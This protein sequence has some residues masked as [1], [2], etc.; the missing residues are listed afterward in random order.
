MLVDFDLVNGRVD[1]FKM[2]VAD[3]GT[4][5]G[6]EKH[7]GGTP[8]YASKVAF[9]RD[10]NKDL[11]AFGRNYIWMSQERDLKKYERYF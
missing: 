8:M 3:W 4:A 11:F 7:Y 10:H 5:G 6:R 9:R 1:N 2:V